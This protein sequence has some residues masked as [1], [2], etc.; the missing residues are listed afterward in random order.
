VKK[1]LFVLLLLT[2]VGGIAQVAAAA[3]GEQAAGE[4]ANGMEAKGMMARSDD[5][6]AAP[7][8]DFSSRTPLYKLCPSDSFEVDFP[9]TPEYNQSLTIRP[10]GFVNFRELGDM[11]IAGLTLPELTEKLK[12]SYSGFLHD[13]VVNITLKEFNKPYVVVGGQ[14]DKPGKYELRA[15]MTVTEVL[16][17]AGAFNERAKHS[18][19][20]LVRKSGPEW[21]EVRTLDVKAMMKD[22]LREDVHLE[23]GDMI[24]VPKNFIS[25]IRPWIPINNLPSAMAHF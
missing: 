21:A 3:T 4:E 14:V 18:Q 6:A 5:R 19:V 2:L 25:K 12:Q 1:L 16:A 7:S 17:M 23:S 8:P 13:P 22:G 11:H 10:D 15:D 24:F 20:L 9:Y